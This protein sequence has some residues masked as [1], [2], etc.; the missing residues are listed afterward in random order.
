[1]YGIPRVT[2]PDSVVQYGE[3]APYGRR[4]AVTAHD[5]VHGGKQ[6]PALDKSLEWRGVLAAGAYAH[7][8]AYAKP[9]GDSQ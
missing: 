6:S 4:Q 8:R 1:M 9:G 7:W 3:G 5:V 2:R